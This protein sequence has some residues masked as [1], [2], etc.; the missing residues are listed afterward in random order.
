MQCA[1]EFLNGINDMITNNPELYKE[2][3]DQDLVDQMMHAVC[4]S[5][6]EACLETPKQHALIPRELKTY[7][8]LR[9]PD[10]PETLLKCETD[11]LTE[12][13]KSI[14]AFDI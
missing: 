4:D 5:E 7:N 9:I 1:I 12:A 11:I 6:A 14:E 10:S 2:I 3:V 13:P 8:Q